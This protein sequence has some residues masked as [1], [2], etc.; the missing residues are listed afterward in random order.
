MKFTVSKPTLIGQANIGLLTAIMVTIFCTVNPAQ[1]A[2]PQT[3]L[4][5]SPKRCVALRQGQ[6][7]YQEVVF[8]WR[9]M[10]VANYC[11]VEITTGGLLQ[12][13]QNANSGRLV[14]D[15]Q[16]A[17]SLD[18]ALRLQNTDENLA[19]AQVTVAWVFKSSKR[20]KSSWKLF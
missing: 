7:C 18:Y 12:C 19:L 1:A 13:W 11:M 14:I 16:S 9:N 2:E 3:T 8:E 20:P 15:F 6:T 4:D 17:Q 5:L 10:P